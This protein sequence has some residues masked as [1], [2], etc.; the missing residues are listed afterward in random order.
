[1]GATE[2]VSL[3]I[4]VLVQSAGMDPWLSIERFGQVPTFGSIVVPGVQLVWVQGDTALDQ[5]A[6]A[7]LLDNI[8][9]IFF[10]TFHHRRRA[11]RVIREITSRNL[12]LSR[13]ASLLLGLSDARVLRVSQREGGQRVAVNASNLLHL[14]PTKVK[15][16]LTYVTKNYEFDYLLRTTSNCYVN[17][18]QLKELLRTAPSRR[19]YAGDVLELAG[20]PFVSGAGNLMSRDVAEAL[21]A[22]LVHMRVDLFEDVAIAELV[23]RLDIAELSHLPRVDI[24]NRDQI[25]GDAKDAWQHEAIIRCKVESITRESQPVI[26]LLRAVHRALHGDKS[27]LSTSC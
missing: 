12:A 26:D 8:G 19:F 13:I 9:S 22:N 11:V 17:Q 5:R 7:R 4:L 20:I 3:K 25:P 14:N 16:V 6:L 21:V 10:N 15:K 24:R 23:R 1:M 18:E 27:G 2:A